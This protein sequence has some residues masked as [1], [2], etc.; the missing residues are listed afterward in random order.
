MKTI[1]FV[2]LVAISLTALFMARQKTASQMAAVQAAQLA[3][4]TAAAN[5]TEVA[6]FGGGCFW[7]TEAV[8]QELKGVKSV[9][10]GYMGG[11]V[12]NPTYQQICDGDTGHAE[13]VQI[14]Y[15]PKQVSFVQLLEVFWETHDPTTLNRQGNDEGTQ[16]RSAI[17][18]YSEAQRKTAQEL[19]EKL[20][21]SGAFKKLIV[22]EIV[23]A[24]EF[25]PAEDY[26]QNY[27]ANNS[28]KPYCAAIIRPK[29]DKLK[30]VFADRLKED[31]QKKDA[32][33]TSPKQS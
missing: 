30:K 14:T 6:T 17:F 24:R 32:P 3:A 11:S 18:Y 1:A 9:V 20:D 8:F 22:T 25:Y 15:D 2:G 31:A 5:A 13:V 33:I 28:R 4:Q 26:H 12:A 29:L 7:C 23:P 10:S 27:Y 19:K 21:K 16:Y